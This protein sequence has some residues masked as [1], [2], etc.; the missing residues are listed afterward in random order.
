MKARASRPQAERSAASTE[1]MLAAAIEL[2]IEHGARVSLAA[3]G[4]R[5]GFS[6]G[7]VLAR[8]GSKAQLIHKVTREVQNRFAANV[9]AATHNLTGF[10]ALE[11]A[12]NVFFSETATKSAQGLAFYVLLGEAVGPDAEIREAF[13]AADKAFRAFIERMLIEAKSEIDPAVDIGAVAALLVGMLRG[14]GMQARV[15]PN[16]IEL[17]RA[18]C[19]AIDLARRLRAAPASRKPSQR[20]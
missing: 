9:A 20:R 8:F 5:A 16:A 7:L 15:N 6:H 13:V 14:V 18:R 19:A 4:Q 10:A 11:A 1:A 12:I 3:I 17:E 2:I